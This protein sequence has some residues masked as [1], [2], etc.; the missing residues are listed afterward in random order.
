MNDQKENYQKTCKEHI[1]TKNFTKHMKN[2]SILA[3]IA[4]TKNSEPKINALIGAG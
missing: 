1:I 4:T 2:L 3:N